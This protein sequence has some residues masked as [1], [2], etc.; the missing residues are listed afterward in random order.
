MKEKIP[1]SGP[2]LGLKI[3]PFSRSE[4]SG[5]NVMFL[6]AD[7]PV[8]E[9]TQYYNYVHH[10]EPPVQIQTYY[11]FER[12]VNLIKVLFLGALIL[13]LTLFSF[14]RYLLEQYPHLFTLGH[15][16]KQGPTRVQIDSTRFSTRLI[17]K[18]WSKQSSTDQQ[19]TVVVSGRDPG[20]LATSVCI[21]Q[22]GLTLLNE[23]DKM[24]K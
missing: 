16:T 13:P 24:P 4:F 7:K 23:S 5:V 21:V 15:F 22:S 19:M 8:A 1:K 2:N 6:G 11:T 12:Y 17:G 14:G 20:Y 9:R 18:G 10:K 3:L